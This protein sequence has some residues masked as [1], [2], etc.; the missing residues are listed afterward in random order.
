MCTEHEILDVD[1]GIYSNISDKGKKLYVYWAVHH[2][3]S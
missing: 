2:L 1:A 3:D